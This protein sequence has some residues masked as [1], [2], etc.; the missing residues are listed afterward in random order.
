VAKR[1]PPAFVVRIFENIVRGE[2]WVNLITL[3]VDERWI[4]PGLDYNSKPLRGRIHL[5]PNNDP[6]IVSS[7]IAHEG[8]HFSS[9][10][11]HPSLKAMA[12]FERIIRSRHL[13]IIMRALV[14]KIYYLVF[15][16][17]RMREEIEAHKEEIRLL[18]KIG[19]P[20]QAIRMSDEESD[21]LMPPMPYSGWIE[22]I[23]RQRMQKIQDALTRQAEKEL[24]GEV[25]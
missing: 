11:R 17:Q 5:P 24:A 20:L 4:I 3:D 18:N 23:F 12:I 1:S 9:F 15:W 8:G 6:F 22:R 25:N 2:P 14:R 16:R 13:P 7:W 10:Y 21:R 19:C